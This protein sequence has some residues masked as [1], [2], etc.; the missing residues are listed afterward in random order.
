MAEIIIISDFLGILQDLPIFHRLM[1]VSSSS[2]NR[3]VASLYG[4]HLR[5]DRILQHIAILPANDFSYKPIRTLFDAAPI[6]LK[7]PM[8]NLCSNY[9]QHRGEY[10]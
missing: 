10:T 6:W 5:F 4:K 9:Y 7:V 1:L 3:E 8:L 2:T